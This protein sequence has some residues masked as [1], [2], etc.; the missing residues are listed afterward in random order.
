[1]TFEEI[2]LEALLATRAQLVSE[3]RSRLDGTYKL[4][5]SSFHALKPEWELIGFPTVRNPPRSPME[6]DE[7]GTIANRNP[8]KYED[9][10]E[11]LGA[12]FR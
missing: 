6:A 3:V 7:S 2:S 9:L 4:F 12:M 11:D 8:Q 10:L 1:M 5:L